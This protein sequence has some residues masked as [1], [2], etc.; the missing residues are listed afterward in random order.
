M[1][2]VVELVAHL[3]SQ[4][5]VYHSSWIFPNG[6]HLDGCGVENGFGFDTFPFPQHTTRLKCRKNAWIHLNH[7][8]HR[9]FP[10]DVKLLR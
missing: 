8:Y 4:L 1:P 9:S 10:S 7:I 3:S 6:D 5:I 2:C